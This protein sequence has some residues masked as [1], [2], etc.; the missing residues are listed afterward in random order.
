[1]SEEVYLIGCHVENEQQADLLKRLVN[2]LHFFSKDFVLVSHTPL[3]EE[4]INKSVGYIYDKSNPVYWRWEFD[5]APEFQFSC[6]KFNILSKYIL[7]GA[8]P[9]YHVG[10]IRLLINGLKY[11]KTLDYKLI[12]WI[13]YDMFPDFDRAEENKKLISQGNQFVFHGLG[14]FFSLDSK[15]QF[16]HNLDSLNN[17][18]ILGLLKNNKYV[19][20]LVIMND[21]FKPEP[22]KVFDV[23]KSSGEYSQNF[24]KVKIHW[25]LFAQNEQ[26]VHMFL[27]NKQ[28]KEVIVNF[29]YNDNSSVKILLPNMYHRSH[30]GWLKLHGKSKIEIKVDGQ[31]FFSLEDDSQIIY[32]KLIKHTKVWS[33][34]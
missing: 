3:P 17:Q 24:D 25:S 21:L 28:N 34:V 29:T 18:I 32:D 6:P 10:V 11:L 20:E 13:E 1:M 30:L 2:H 23:L 5:D 14:S 15:I 4:C 12:H 19:A 16:K 27:L 33:D 31:V 7:Y 22:L 9:Y 26:E 8:S